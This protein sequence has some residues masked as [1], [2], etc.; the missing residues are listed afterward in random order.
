MPGEFNKAT[1]D[2]RIL[3]ESAAA[4]EAEFKATSFD[5]LT[6]NQATL[7]VIYHKLDQVKTEYLRRITEYQKRR[8]EIQEFTI[9]LQ[10]VNQQATDE[11]LVLPVDEG[12]S[13]VVQNEMSLREL[14][15]KLKEKG[16]PLTLKDKYDVRE[17]DNLI[18]NLKHGLEDLS[19]QNNITMEHIQQAV[20]ERYEA[21]QYARAI[22][23]AGHEANQQVA[24]NI[25][26]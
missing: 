26:K 22:M 6:L 23:K 19:Y 25:A 8:E 14:L 5:G 10:L 13:D 24:R 11:G 16:C 15:E 3:D 21:Y 2:L 9:A 12:K 18:E 17:R 4:A 1:D 7:I 20:N